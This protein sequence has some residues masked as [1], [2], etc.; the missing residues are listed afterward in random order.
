MIVKDNRGRSPASNCKLDAVI[1]FTGE[2]NGYVCDR[3]H[4]YHIKCRD[5]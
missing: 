3:S 4:T 1:G 5:L 2:A